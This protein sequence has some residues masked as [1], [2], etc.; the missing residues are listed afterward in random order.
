MFQNTG[1][2]KT[3]N[4][5]QSITERQYRLNLTT[6][7]LEEVT[8]YKIPSKQ[9]QA[10]REMGFSPLVRPRDGRPLLSRSEYEGHKSEPELNWSAIG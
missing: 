3:M 6:E 5:Q 7:E 9:L 8:G 2:Y 10:L 4:T 1:V